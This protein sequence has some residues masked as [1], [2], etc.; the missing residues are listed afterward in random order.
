MPTLS[1]WDDIDIP[2][3]ARGGTVTL[4][5][6]D[7]LSAYLPKRPGAYL[8]ISSDR[9][10]LEAGVERQRED[11][12][13]TRARLRWGAFAKIYKENDTSAFKKRKVTRPDGSVDWVVLRPKFR[14]LLADLAAGV[15][16]GVVFYDLDRLVRQPRDLEDLIDVVEYVQRPAVGATGGRMNLINDSDR[17]MARMMCVMALKSSEDTARRVARQHLSC[18]QSGRIQG[19]IGYGWTR[20]G[21][22]K[23]TRLHP[24]AKV[25]EGLFQDVLSGE[26]AYSVAVA[27]NRCGI[28]PPAAARWSSTMV[29]KILRNSRYAGMVAY[30]GRHRIDPATAWDGWSHVLFDDD[31]HPLL[32]CWEPIVE[33]KI[34]SQVQFELQLRRQRQGIPPGTGLPAVTS[35]YLLSGILTC[36]RCGRGLVGHKDKA[37]QTRTYRCP[38]PGHGGCS[39]TSIAAAPAE[40]A[41]EEGIIRFL[42]NLLRTPVAGPSDDTETLTDLRATLEH[43]SSRKQALLNRWSEGT[44]T[45]AGLTEEDLYQLLAGLNRKIS[46]LRDAIAA[47]EGHPPTPNPEADVLNGWHNGTLHQRRALLK[48]YLQRI[49][50]LP[51]VQANVFNRSPLVRERLSPVW[52]GEHEIAA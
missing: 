20:T 47:A 36:G 39:G 23:G 6:Y 2:P 5:L 40:Q 52:R 21:P 50:V 33:P 25:I 1:L 43:D 3:H 37:K 13:D 10:G 30:A 46:R 26:T 12:E 31:G 32:G 7:H 29:N 51:P 19:R 48:R 42:Q 34:W 9:F 22:D 15:I 35:K 27:L 17:H 28:T 18:A 24:E 8:R 49:K 41:I 45:Q 16:D 38:P 14:L 11:T 4:N 44:L